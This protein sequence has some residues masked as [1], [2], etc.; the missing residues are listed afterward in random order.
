[1]SGIREYYCRKCR[2]LAPHERMNEK[3]SCILCAEK[4]H[5]FIAPVYE[6]EPELAFDEKQKAPETKSNVIEF[7]KKEN[8]K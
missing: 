6:H 5:G 2:S 4:A 7:K 3:P 8:E 1:M